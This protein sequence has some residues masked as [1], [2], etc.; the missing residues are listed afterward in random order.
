MLKAIKYNKKNDII[1]E[2]FIKGRE[3]TVSV[4]NDQVLPI[5][6]IIPKSG[7]YDYNSKYTSGK[8]SCLFSIKLLF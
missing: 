4:L 5:V 2:D 3:L 1:F 6:E 7:V 8:S